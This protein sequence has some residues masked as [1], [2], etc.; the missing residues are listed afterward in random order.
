MPGELLQGAELGRATAG[1][2][3]DAHGG[4]VELL[5]GEVG[6]ADGGVEE[7]EGGV[8]GASLGREEGDEG[9]DGVVDAHLGL[10]AELLVDGGE[11]LVVVV[12]EGGEVVAL[13]G[14]DGVPAVVAH[15]VDDDV[16]VVGEE[17]PEG[18]VEVDGEAVAVAHDEARPVR[19]A[20]PAHGDDGVVVHAHGER[21]KGLGDL[22]GHVLTCHNAAVFSWRTG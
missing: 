4:R 8:G 9:G 18:V 16:V 13:E 3:G 10:G 6:P 5:V 21:G 11:E 20:V 22:P 12:D 1:E 17:R 14:A 7:D 19:V 15:V 2:S